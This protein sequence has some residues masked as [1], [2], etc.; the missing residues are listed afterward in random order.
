MCYFNNCTH[1]LIDCD[2]IIKGLL[3]GPSSCIWGAMLIGEGNGN[4]LQ[5]SCLEN[6]VGGGA[7]WAA[8]HRVAQ[9]QTRLRR[10]SVHACIGEGNGNPLQYSCLENA[11]GREA[12]WVAVHG[13]SQSQT[14]LKRLSSSSSLLENST[15]YCE[16]TKSLS[17]VICFFFF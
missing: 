1:L 3:C 7:W 12:W 6:P 8:I 5:Y 10:L 14:R 11:R 16:W 4:P 2:K 13:V 15:N 17:P 9:S